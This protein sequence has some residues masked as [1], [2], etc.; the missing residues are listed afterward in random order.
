VLRLPADPALAIAHF[1]YRDVRQFLDRAYRYEAIAASAAYAGGTRF[2]LLRAVGGSFRAATSR[3]V[4]D[5]GYR[6]G[7]R[8]VLLSGLMGVSRL[9]FWLH[10]WELQSASP[11]LQDSIR[12]QL[13]DGWFP[14]E[15][16]A[17]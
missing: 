11:E 9:L 12:R 13:A 3:L 14:P 4:M 6:D 10:L 2:S 17:R 15:D 1:S 5:R 16:A 7:A 8:G